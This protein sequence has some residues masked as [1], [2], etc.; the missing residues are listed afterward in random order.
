MAENG[1]AT[2]QAL[3]RVEANLMKEI[4]ANKANIKKNSE[5]IIEL[6]VLYKTLMT[7]PETIASLDKTVIGVNQ[8]LEA[9]NAKIEDIQSK[10]TN[11]K[12]SIKDLREENKQQNEQIAK[13]DG[14]SKIDWIEF[15]T[16]HFWKVILIIGV[17]Y[18]LGKD[19]LSAVSKG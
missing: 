15:I 12:A 2:P 6:K 1:C 11:Q 10:I 19:I 3:D 17:L 5:S 16:K 18:Y 9:M 14:K 8:N 7:L 4:E 13:I